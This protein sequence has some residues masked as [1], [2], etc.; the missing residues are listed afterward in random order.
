MKGKPNIVVMGGSFNPPTIAHL[1]LIQAAVNALDAQTGY[2]VPVS[3]AYLKRK[4]VKAGCGHLC[5][6]TEAR[7]QMLRAMIAEDP[8]IRIYEGDLNEPFAITNQTM[9]LIQEIHPEARI[10]F[11]AGEDK[12][13]LLESL[14][15]KYAFLPRFG[16]V[17]FARGGDLERNIAANPGLS[18]CRDAVTILRL[19]VETE[20]V[21]STAIRAHLF[22]PDA[23]AEMLHPAVLPLVRQLR[24][25]DF[26]EEIIAFNEE[27][28]F[29]GNAFPAPVV[30]EEIAYPSA[31]AAFQASKC[32]DL[33]MRRQF[34]RFSPEKVRQK[35]NM[36]TP[37]SGWE[38]EKDDIMREIV[39]QKFLQNPGLGERLLDT[40]NRTLID[41]G[42]GKKDTCWGVNTTT[43][44]GENRLGKLL[45]A[46]REQM[47]KEQSI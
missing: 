6:P 16:A 37:R 27:H 46:L 34:A 5:I 47:R 28:A 14:T 26:P 4:M 2:L 19:P 32:D 44:E 15:Q 43:W 36:V 17:V 1:K 35:G 39:R 31:E 3:H 12:L 42:K 33:A 38:A 40:G 7:L 45:M 13:E 23:V 25:E 20:G 10:W 18:A 9:A 24:E 41:G 30:F 21:S 29:L 8:R 11:V 22:D